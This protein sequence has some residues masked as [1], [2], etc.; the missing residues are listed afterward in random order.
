[1]FDLEGLQIIGLDDAWSGRSDAQAAWQHIDPH[2]PIL[3]LNHDPKDAGDLLDYPWH[4]M[5]SGHT[6]GRQITNRATRRQLP[7]RHRR[8]VAGLYHVRG[9]HLYVNRGASYGQRAK[10]DCRPEITVFKLRSTGTNGTA[11]TGE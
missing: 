4:W 1:M 2:R 5:L 11:L 9:R 10:D 6:H 8:Y 3:V 7:G